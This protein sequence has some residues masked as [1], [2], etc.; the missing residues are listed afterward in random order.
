[1]IG[2]L[3]ALQALGMI[4]LHVAQEISRLNQLLASVVSN[5]TA[6]YGHSLATLGTTEATNRFLLD[7]ELALLPEEGT[8]IPYDDAGG[9]TG[10][11][12]GMDR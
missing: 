6:Y 8:L 10:L 3:E 1:M 4:D 11:P 7:T 2:N 9:F 12:P 5:Q